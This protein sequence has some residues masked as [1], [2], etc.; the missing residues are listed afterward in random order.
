MSKTDQNSGQ[1]MEIKALPG[2][3]KV[4]LEKGQFE[5]YASTFGNVDVYGDKIL[6]DAFD[7]TLADESSRVKVFY[8]HDYWVPPI[9]RPELM[10]PD[11]YGL[12]TVTKVLETP[13]G[14]D[15]LL[16]I[17]EGVLDSLSIGFT[18]SDWRMLEED[19]EQIR[20]ISRIKLFEYSVV[21]W[22][23]NELARITGVKG[24]IGFVAVDGDRS[25]GRVN[26]DDRDIDQRDYA[27]MRKA[28]QGTDPV[29][30]LE[31]E[32]DY[33]GELIGEIRSHDPEPGSLVR[34]VSSLGRVHADLSDLAPAG[35]DGEDLSAFLEEIRSGLGECRQV[36]AGA[37]R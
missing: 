32:V 15:T 4:D 26:L 24:R 19:E 8:G 27:A 35:N 3:L 16:G 5:G 12:H 11:D 9:G 14:K 31:D 25:G 1:V 20:E 7:D 18:P 6:P 22:G 23:A 13:L 29:A 17:R 34:A 2:E 21:P 37:G 10:T 33:L 36:L 30:L 28:L